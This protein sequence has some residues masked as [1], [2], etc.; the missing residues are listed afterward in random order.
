MTRLLKAI[1]PDSLFYISG[2]WQLVASLALASSHAEKSSTC[3]N[4][5]LAKPAYDD[6]GPDKQKNGVVRVGK[7]TVQ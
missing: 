4:L 2:L 1:L 6:I 3:A 5:Q 7:L